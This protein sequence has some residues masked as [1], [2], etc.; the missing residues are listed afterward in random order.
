MKGFSTRCLSI[1]LLLL[2]AGA[3]RADD[4]YYLLV[5]GAQRMPPEP[6]YSHS[7]A[8]FIH[9]GDN[10]AAALEGH[11]ISWLPRTLKLNA[12]ALHPEP[13]GNLP[14]FPTLHW[15]LANSMRVSLWGPY[16]IK[17]EL[18]DKAVAQQALLES[19]KI[20]YKLI[21]ACQFPDEVLNCIHAI[22]GVAGGLRFRTTIFSWGETASYQLTRHFQPWIIKKDVTHDWLIP[23]LG[24]YQF[25]IV[26]RNLEDPGSGDFPTFVRYKK[27]RT[28]H[29][30]QRYP[31]P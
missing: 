30:L 6:N 29:I 26:Y 23:V 25:P 10:G 13:G 1:V 9:A 7:F 24:L 16:E 14:I 27:G 21:D 5:F 31:A 3:V 11:Y 12:A 15:A 22:S 19:G 8:L 18:Y 4:R 28:E 17:R 2:L 20:K